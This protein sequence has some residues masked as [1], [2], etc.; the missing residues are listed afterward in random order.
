[1]LVFAHLVSPLDSVL[2]A[3]D[4][5]DFY[6]DSCQIYIKLLICSLFVCRMLLRLDISN[7]LL[8]LE[9]N[10]LQRKDPLVL[11]IDAVQN[12]DCFLER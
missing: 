7:H 4:L 2:L 11:L 9:V 8:L 10:G 12:V 6:L 3:F 1:M 5:V